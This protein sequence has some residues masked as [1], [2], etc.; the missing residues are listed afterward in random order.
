MSDINKDLVDY[1]NSLDD[2]ESKETVNFVE[3]LK[4]PSNYKSVLDNFNWSS[5]YFEKLDDTLIL[6]G[7]QGHADVIQEI[8]K[9]LTEQ[10]TSVS[11][12]TYNEATGAKIVDYSF[13]SKTSVDHLEYIET[14]NNELSQLSRMRNDHNWDGEAYPSGVAAWMNSLMLVSAID[15]ERKNNRAKLDHF[16]RC[17]LPKSKLKL[18]L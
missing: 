15:D 13:K 5:E 12:K 4:K 1:V 2:C 6:L 10:I 16:N 9:F 17:M 3:K 8:K 11:V 14:I 18:V 7:Y